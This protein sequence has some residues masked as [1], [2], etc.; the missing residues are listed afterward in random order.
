MMEHGIEGKSILCVGARHD[1]EVDFF[2]DKGHTAVGIDLFDTEKIINCDMSRIYEHPKLK[3]YRFDI[4]FSC[5]SLEHCLDLKGFAKSLRLVCEKYFV[6]LFTIARNIRFWDCHRPDFVDY[7][8][9]DR[10]DEE[11]LKVFPGFELVIN[12]VHKNSTRGFFILKKIIK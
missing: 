3:N 1:C 7:I 2:I 11:L 9:T 4:V 8:G 10:Y 6:C 12:E 5:E